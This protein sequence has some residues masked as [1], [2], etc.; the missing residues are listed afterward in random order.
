MAREA[1]PAFG[2]EILARLAPDDEVRIET[3]DRHA[4]DGPPRSTIIWIVVSDGDVFVRSVRGPRGRWFRDLQADPSATLVARR[5]PKWPPVPVEAVLADD[6]ASIARCS[7]ALE[8]K[9]SGDPALRS[10]LQPETLA[11]TLRL[12]PRGEG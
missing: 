8:R 10:M 5:A 9:Y 3:V 1:E 2:P 6:P 11:T 4:P 12:R 7:E